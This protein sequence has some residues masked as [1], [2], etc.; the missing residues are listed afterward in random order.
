MRCFVLLKRS[1]AAVGVSFIV[2]CHGSRIGSLPL[3]LWQSIGYVDALS[4]SAAGH[5]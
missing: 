2:E 5:L 4:K 1:R 3:S